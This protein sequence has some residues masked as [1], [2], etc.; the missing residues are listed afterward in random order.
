MSLTVCS[1]ALPYKIASGP[2]IEFKLAGSSAVQVTIPSGTYYPD[3]DTSGSSNLHKAICDALTSA[4]STGSWAFSEIA[5]DYRGRWLIKRAQSG[6][7]ELEYLKSLTAEVTMEDLGFSS[8]SVSPDSGTATA[9]TA[10]LTPSDRTGGSWVLNPLSGAGIYLGGLERPL[11]HC[12]STTSPSGVTT[13]DHYGSQTVKRI[14]FSTLPAASVYP[15]FCSDSAYMAA[16]GA[17]AGDL[18]SA[19]DTL[20]SKWASLDTSIGSARFYPDISAPSAYVSVQ[21][22]QGQSWLSSL[23][24]A[25]QEVSRAPLLYDLTIELFKVA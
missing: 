4:D 2:Q 8:T 12:V 17:T 15:F 10:V 25:A 16:L 9:A 3:H 18:N 14:E 24:S 11:S 22:G 7:E 21:P 23:D 5:G 6:G 19:F 13:I 1:F 20:R